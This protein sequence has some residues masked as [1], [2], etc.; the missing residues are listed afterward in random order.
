MKHNQTNRTKG[1]RL[2]KMVRSKNTIHPNKNN[3]SLEDSMPS[4][5]GRY[6]KSLSKFIKSTPKMQIFYRKSLMTA[7]WSSGIWNLDHINNSKNCQRMNTNPWKTGIRIATKDMRK[8]TRAISR[9]LLSSTQTRYWWHC[10][11]IQSPKT[12][13]H[14][15]LQFW[16]NTYHHSCKTTTPCKHYHTFWMKSKNMANLLMSWLKY[17]RRLLSTWD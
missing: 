14:I 17:L 16:R 5:R 11:V 8:L 10:W 2:T 7:S 13:N 1:W 9:S 3:R 4:L 12:L 6:L 15:L